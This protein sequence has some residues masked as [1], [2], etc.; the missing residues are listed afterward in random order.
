MDTKTIGE[1]FQKAEELERDISA[2][3][4]KHL[5]GLSYGELFTALAKVQRMW[6]RFLLEDE[7]SESTKPDKKRS[8][9]SE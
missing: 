8:R 3:I 4:S 6:S 1:R 9:S 2:C 7:W 5:P